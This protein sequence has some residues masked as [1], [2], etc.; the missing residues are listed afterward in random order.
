MT[1]EQ[2]VD[3]LL[4]LFDAGQARA[5]DVVN[6]RLAR[7]VTEAEYLRKIMS[8]GTTVAGQASY[9][10]DS[11]VT[12]ILQ[13]RIDFT[14]GTVLY[15]GTET[16]ED[17]WRVDAGAA[18]AGPGTFVVIEPDSD[19]SGN[20]D[21]F[22]LYPAPA[23]AGLS[24]QALVVVQPA[25]LTYSSGTALPIPLDAHEQLLAGCKAELHDEEGRQDEAAKFEAVFGSGI[26]KLSKR[27]QSRGKGSSGH[28][29]RVRGYDAPR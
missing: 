7:M 2:L 19:G 6:E 18:D 1:F 14:D 28:R 10:L 3:R 20:T 16:L 4:S 15:D 21:N 29:L 23:E 12:K 11:T 25:T 8:L 26:S 13:V 5:V 9:P 22:R 17:L 27:V 24:V